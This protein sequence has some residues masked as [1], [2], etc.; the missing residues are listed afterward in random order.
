LL[1]TDAYYQA[2]ASGV[3]A[4]QWRF[5]LA[6]EVPIG[7]EVPDAF[8]ALILVKFISLMCRDATNNAQNYSKI[9]K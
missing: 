6:V 2:N 3:H 5:Q 4:R 9:D 8:Q 7:S 1:K